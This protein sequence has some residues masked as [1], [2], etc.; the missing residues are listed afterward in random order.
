MAQYLGEVRGNRGT[1]S[2]LGSKSSGLTVIAN[3]WNVGARVTISYDPDRGDVVNVWR[4]GG[5]NGAGGWTLIAEFAQNDPIT[6][7][8]EEAP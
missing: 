7:I 2:R 4:T 1:V 5:S 3:G 8:A 6:P